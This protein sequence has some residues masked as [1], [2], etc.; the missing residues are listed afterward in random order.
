MTSPVP[1]RSLKQS[2]EEATSEYQNQLAGSPGASLLS[3]RGIDHQTIEHFRLGYVS[4]PISGDE[5]Y[6][7]YISIPYITVSGIVSL[8]FKR[9]TGSGPKALAY[10]GSIARPYNIGALAKR[11]PMF[12]AEGEPD[13]WIARQCGLSTTGVSGVDSWKSVWGRAFRFCSR[14]EGGAGLYIL[15]QGDTEPV[16]QI[17][18]DWFTA[19]ELLT[20]SIKESLPGAETIKFPPNEDVNSLFLKHGAQALRGWVGLSG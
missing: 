19:A 18:E 4:T 15:Q 2:L 7:G 11:G 10:E 3:Q 5:G 13:T 14:S 1:S 9:V 6:T 8:R 16:R 20:R 17:G 12:I